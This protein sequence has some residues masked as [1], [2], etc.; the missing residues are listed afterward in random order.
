MDEQ[1]S[2]QHLYDVAKRLGVEGRSRMTKSELLDAVRKANRSETRK[3]R[4]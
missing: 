3:A 4:N 2:K 1:A